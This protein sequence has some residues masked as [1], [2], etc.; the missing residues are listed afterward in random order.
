MIQSINNV[1]LLGD[2]DLEAVLKTVTLD[3][4]IIP[5]FQASFPFLA[6]IS[7]SSSSSC[8]LGC[9]LALGPHSAWEASQESS[10]ELKQSKSEFSLADVRGSVYTVASK[11]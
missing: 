10:E 7:S 1:I 9:F 11:A 6:L 8:L 2:V 4:T 3:W 5:P